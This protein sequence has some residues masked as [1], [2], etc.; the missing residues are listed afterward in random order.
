MLR[1]CVVVL[2]AAFRLTVPEPEPLA[3]VAIVS[4]EAP[5]VA[6]HEHPASVLTPTDAAPPAAGADCVAGDRVYEQLPAACETDTLCPPTLTVVERALV[7]E[8]CAAVRPIVPLPDPLPFDVT[9][10][11]DAPLVAVQLQPDCAVTATLTP[12]PAA[13]TDWDAGD[14]PYVQLAAG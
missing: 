2:A 1:V 6:V 3:P 11:H 9:V 10:N 8:F 12:P 4:H 5:V 7:V 14:A 13:P